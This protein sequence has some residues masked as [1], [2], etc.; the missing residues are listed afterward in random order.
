MVVL[1]VPPR[2]KK[3]LP[4]EPIP[5]AKKEGEEEGAGNPAEGG[6]DPE[7]GAQHESDEAA[8]GADAQSEA[9]GSV[10]GQDQKQVLTA[11]YKPESREAW[12]EALRSANEKA[13]QVSLFATAIDNFLS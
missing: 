12:K 8:R 2:P 5:A 3:T 4:E 11:I 9:G 7:A 1:P 6:A 10:E 13:E